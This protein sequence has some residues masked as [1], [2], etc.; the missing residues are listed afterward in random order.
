MTVP[1]IFTG[2]AIPISRLNTNFAAVN[3]G[4]N[5]A[6]TVNASAQP[7]ITSVGTLTSVSVTGNVRAGSVYTN[8]YYY[9]NGVSIITSGSSGAQGIQ[10][11][12]GT[13]IQGTT[14][15]T[16]AQ[17]TT[18]SGTQ[19]VQ[20]VTGS[21]TQGVDG[22]NGA[23]GTTGTTGAQGVTGSGTQG[24]QGVSGSQG[25][26]GAQGTTGSGTQGTT[27]A[28]GTTGTGFTGN[29][30]SNVNGQGYS[31]SNVGN[32]SSGN[33]I[34]G[35]ITLTN[36][37][38]LKD[39]SGNSISFGTIETGVG[40]GN[41]SIA[42]GTAAGGLFQ[43]D[44]AVAIGY[45]AGASTQNSYAIAIGFY[46]GQSE[47]SSNTIAIGTNAGF[48]GQTED[49]IAIGRL[50]GVS[51]PSGVQGG[52]A[53]AIGTGAG[54]DGQQLE[55]IAIG[56]LAANSYQG[57]GAI[58]IGTNAGYDVQ[59]QQA[60]AIG[61]ASGNNQGNL[62]VAIGGAAGGNAQG[63]TAIA[64][65]TYAGQDSQ[66]QQAIAIGVLAGNSN[67]GLNSIAIGTNAGYANQA[68]NTIIFNAT[69]NIL[70]QTTANTFTVDP[71]RNDLINVDQVLFYNPGSKEITYGNT[72]N[73]TGNISGNYLLGNG[74]QITGIGGPI[75]S[76]RNTGNT[77]SQSIPIGNSTTVLVYPTTTTNTGN[78]YNTSTGRFTPL[79]SGHYQINVTTLP[80][81]T[82]GIGS[83]NFFIALYKN[84]SA[85]PLATGTVT[86]TSGV[87]G[88]SLISTLVFFN[89]ST[90]YVT[91]SL[92]S[93]VV[94]GTWITSAIPSCYFQAAWLR[95]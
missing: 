24:T 25:T 28:Q 73:V 31:I 78:Y 39:S 64:I 33:I 38:I 34:T 69:G 76:A 29:L 56:L 81:L 48:S 54:N 74:S 87:I 57:S 90:D 32:I 17:G 67:Q 5:T 4:V 45:G 92:N 71:V 43:Q 12:Q 72:I 62:A 36:G 52:N 91:I 13:S 6:N 80:E 42:I 86:D 46:A 47:Q 58:A 10:G 68:N 9:A 26:T 60:I 53:I 35:I 44:N 27:G 18:G 15:T 93:S 75:V 94:S 61:V 8:N 14:G 19:G 70:N 88:M 77:A 49:A 41:N 22:A 55:A 30:T 65:G 83:G 3:A 51:G 79:V 11:I 82:A 50:A 37:A 66:G 89:G 85:T 23:Q 95:T 21:G 59:G 1:Y 2:N 84:S 7:A 40:Q 20:G 16:G 63:A